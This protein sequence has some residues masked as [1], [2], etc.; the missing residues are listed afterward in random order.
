MFK[1]LLLQI[2]PGA[3]IN[4]EASV[5]NVKDLTSALNP[6]TD[7]YKKLALECS[8]QYIAVDLFFLNN[9]YVDIATIS[10]ASKYS[11]GCIHQFPNYHITRNATQSYHFEQVFQRYLVRKIGFEAVMRI[12]C[13]R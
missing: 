11:G 2:G 9:Q 7:F 4:R 1:C 12:R 13:S 6:T 3:L 8:Q 5:K 10:C